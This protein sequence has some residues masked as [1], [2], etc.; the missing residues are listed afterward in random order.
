[1]MRAA[2][3]MPRWSMTL[4]S[5]GCTTISTA[6]GGAAPSA[7]RLPASRCAMYSRWASAS[8]AATPDSD[9]FSGSRVSSV[10][11]A[12]HAGSLASPSARPTAGACASSWPRATGTRPRRCSA[13]PAGFAAPRP[14]SAGRPCSRSGRCRAV[15]AGRHPPP[16]PPRKARAAAA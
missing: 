13:R 15:A 16:R 6:V 9:A 14:P 12:A 11:A 10:S 4:R 1:M 2:L 7:P 5:V 3:T 8:A